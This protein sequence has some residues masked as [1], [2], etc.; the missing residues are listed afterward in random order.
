MG[1]A[2]QCNTG[3]GRCGPSLETGVWQQAVCCEYGRVSSDQNYIFDG[4][5]KIFGDYRGDPIKITQRK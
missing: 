2:E 4:L 3:S 1:H 5:S